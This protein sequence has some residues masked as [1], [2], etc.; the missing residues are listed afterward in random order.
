M[1]RDSQKKENKVVVKKR[2]YGFFKSIFKPTYW[3][4][5]FENNEEDIN[6]ILLLYISEYIAYHNLSEVGLLSIN[7]TLFYAISNRNLLTQDH[8]NILPLEKRPT[9][10]EAFSWYYA[11]IPLIYP[12][13]A[14]KVMNHTLKPLLIGL[15][16]IGA[17]YLL[18]LGIVILTK[19]MKGSK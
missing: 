19:N 6:N 10:F 12:L 2:V 15:V 18:I 4:S 17:I 7:V 11:T 16:C 8:L 1:G 9:K 3:E 5:Y 14:I 13:F